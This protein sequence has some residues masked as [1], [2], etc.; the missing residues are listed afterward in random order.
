MAPTSQFA[1]L[2][3]LHDIEELEREPLESRLLS[4][5]ANVWLRRGLDLAPHKIAIRYINDGDPNSAPVEV[6]YAQLKRDSLR[7]AN[8]FHA[9]GVGSG[10]AVLYLL[11]T[12]PQ[13]YPVTIAAMAAGIACSV[14]WMLEP[15]HWIE[16]I[17]GSRAKVVVA[18]GPTPG[19]NIWEKLAE[20]R[21]EIPASVRVLSVQGPGGT[22]L[23]DSDLAL[24]AANQPDD[25]LTFDRVC[26]PDEV[27]AYIHSGGTT[28]SPKLVRLTHRGICYKFWANTL[29]M[30]HSAEDVIFADYPMFH[31]AGFFGR[32]ILAIADGM[33]IVIP[34]PIGARD[35]KFIA[36][37]WKFVDK[38]KI[39]VL[40]GVPTTLAQLSKTPPQGEDVSS[41][42]KYAVTGST[43]FPSEVARRLE[44]QLGVRMFGSYGAT[45]YTQNVAQP[46]R[47]GEAKYGSAGIRLPYS[48]IKI[49]ELDDNG[50]V[51]RECATDEIGLVVVKGPSVTPG[52]VDDKYN[53]GVFTADGWFNSGDLGRIDAEGYLWLTGRAKDV[54]IRGG[55]NI[56][57]M[58][59]EETLL[60]HG[61]VL[62]AAAVAK[63]DSYA[64]E[65]PVAYVQ[66]VAGAKATA[67]DL[68]AFV[69]QHIPERAATPKEIVLLDKM[70]LTDV[71]K[72]QKAQLRID[73]ARRAFTAELADTAGGKISVDMVPDAKKGNMA[74][75]TVAGTA[76]G[77]A[78]IETA[79]GEKMKFYSTPYVVRWTEPESVGP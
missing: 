32:G 72:P 61:D 75:I 67:H 42:R 35:K 69:Q 22:V 71:G 15:A 65:L 33:S 21:A 66:L 79:I 63:P 4:Q 62:L 2:R 23:A 13:F 64:G 54:I 17:K 8:L 43:A 49:V 28:G 38:F 18:L 52:Y 47:D 25:K 30:A 29:V 3:N 60:K 41:L 31:I 73:A 48:Q 57:P 55:H 19:F 77:R 10:D 39:S 44:S 68:I 27:A 56:D 51:L 50:K 5:D 76:A 24:L 59:I 58:V 7:Y 14:N 20:V 37:Y 12:I 78:A 16:L 74:V 1:P 36:N 46:P 9:Q 34:T 45:E 11:P 26:A 40:S 6:T 53:A 70:P